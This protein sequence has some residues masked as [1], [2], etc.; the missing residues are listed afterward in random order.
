[1]YSQIILKLRIY[2][3]Q[4]FAARN[5][6]AE[7][8]LSG[9][10][11]WSSD[12]WDSHVLHIDLKV[13]RLREYIWVAKMRILKMNAVRQIRTT[14]SEKTYILSITLSCKDERLMKDR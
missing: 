9:G 10:L 1:M 14:V 5:I 11:R 12:F 6:D 3:D 2:V 13:S 7:P 8:Y 4:L